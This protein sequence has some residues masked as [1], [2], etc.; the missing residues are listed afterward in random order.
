MR[1]EGVGKLEFYI[2]TV[3]SSPFALAEKEEE[4]EDRGKTVS[5]P[6]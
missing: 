4:E 5:T 1:E 6:K 3:S 2:N